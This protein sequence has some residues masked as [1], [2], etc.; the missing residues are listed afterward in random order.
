MKEP[1]LPP[2]TMVLA[3][4]SADAFSHSLDLNC[5]IGFR[6]HDCVGGNVNSEEPT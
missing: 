2:K 4:L 3:A 5:V 6:N 1:A